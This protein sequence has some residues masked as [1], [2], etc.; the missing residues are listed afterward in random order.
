MKLQFSD[1]GEL[2]SWSGE[3]IL[4][5]SSHPKDPDIEKELVPWRQKLEHFTREIIGTSDVLLKTSRQSESNIGNF[6]TDAMLA[7][8]T[9]KTINGNKIR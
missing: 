1:A 4:L 5:D 9:G 7:A 6:V 2:E 3:P 8:W